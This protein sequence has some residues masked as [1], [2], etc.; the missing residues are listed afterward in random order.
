M[1]MLRVGSRSPT[2]GAVQD[3]LAKLGFSPGR[4]DNIFGPMTEKGVIRFQESR[5]LYA[6]GVVGPVTMEELEEAMVTY[7]REQASPGPDSTNGEESRLSFERCEADATGEGYGHLFLRSDAAE[8]YKKVHEYLRSRGAKLTSSGGKRDLFAKVNAN[9]SAT[10]MHYCGLALDLYIWSAMTSAPENDPYVVRL[11]SLEDRTLDVWAKCEIESVP[12]VAIRDVLT[13][14]DPKFQNK[15]EVTGRYINLT[16]LF[17][18]HGFQPIGFRRRFYEDGAPLA[19]EW[20]HFQYEKALIPNVSTFGGELQKVYS[21]N[22]LEKSPV[23]RYR[24]RIFKINW[25]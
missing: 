16:Q 20:W 24:D 12:E 5:G 25:F 14:H 3:I 1:L 23:W 11:L 9:R 6:D 4:V 17:K 10:S 22:R 18:E 15:K 7:N 13:Y 21:L 8:A 2:V 19:A